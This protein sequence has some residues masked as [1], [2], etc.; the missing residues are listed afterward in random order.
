MLYA[1]GFETIGVVLSDLYF[2][3]PTQRADQE[4]PERGVRLELRML[5]RSEL[6]GSVYSAQPIGIGKPIWRADL[7]E[8]ADGP[9][10]AFDRTHH[11]PVFTGWE[12]SNRVFVEE[13]STNPVDWVG[14]H[15]RNVEGL[16]A[17][18]GIDTA[19]IDPGDLDKLR[20]AVPEIVDTLGRLLERVHAGELGTAPEGGLVSARAGW[21]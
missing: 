21:L 16:L 20:A 3:D 7:L 10:G 2:L 9:P 17:D 13:L 4:G 11:H 18:A 12:P 14:A 1:F 15:L 8:R 6:K 5:E 19:E